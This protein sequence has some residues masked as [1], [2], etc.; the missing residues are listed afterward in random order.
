M[1]NVDIIRAWK[2]EEYRLSLSE[3]ER[4]LLPDNPAGV[5]DLTAAEMAA[6]VGGQAPGQFRVVHGG[7]VFGAGT[8]AA[9]ICNPA[10]CSAVLKAANPSQ[11]SVG[12]HISERSQK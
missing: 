9:P 6:V 8:S 4:G 12:V 11:P 1:T 5:V 7:L 3:T 2:D 10:I